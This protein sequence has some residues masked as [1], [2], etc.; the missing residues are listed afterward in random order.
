TTDNDN[1]KIS[2]GNGVA[3]NPTLTLTETGVAGG[4]Y[5]NPTITVDTYGRVREIESGKSIGGGVTSVSVKESNGFTASVSNPTTTPE[6]SLGTS[7]TGI[8]EG[9]GG[10]LT[11]AA[12]TGTGP[13]VLEDSPKLKNPV[14]E[15]T[16]TGNVSI[17]A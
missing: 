17:D 13:I 14:I 4:Q 12:T 2:N 7:I 1:I 5:T 8:L 3:N 6:I 9:N 10:A 15:G 16:I 11:T